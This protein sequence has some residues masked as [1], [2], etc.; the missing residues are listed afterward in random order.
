MS[1]TNIPL[2]IQPADIAGQQLAFQKP[3][4]DYANQ[5]QTNA[6]TGLIGQQTQAASIA[7]QLAQAKLGVQLPII[8]SMNGD[9]TPNA[10]GIS[11]SMGGGQGGQG[12]GGLPPPTTGQNGMI[13]P[14]LGAVPKMVGASV[15]TSQ[16]W[17]KA[18]S[19]AQNA[20][21]QQI[22]QAVASTMGED[23]KADRAAW[24]QMVE[25]Q[26]QSGWMDSAQRAMLF[27]HPEKATS[28]LSS[29]VSPDQQPWMVG[30]RAAA[31]GDEAAKRDLVTI[32][33]DNGDG[34]TTP[35]QVPRSSVLG[36]AG[37]G[38]S[39][40]GGG[41]LRPDLTTAIDSASK[42]YG[43]PASYLTTTARIENP[44]GNPRAVSPTGA[45]GDFQFTGGTADAVG[46]DRAD[47]TDPKQAARGAARLYLESKA[48]LTPRL[49]RAPTDGEVYLAHQQGVGGATALLQADPGAKAVDVYAAAGIPVKNLLVNGG[50]RDMTVGQF[51]N[52]WTSRFDQPQAQPTAAAPG[53]GVITPPGQPGVNPNGLVAT[54]AAGGV[55]SGPPAP[56][57]TT[58]K[59][60]DRDTT[61]LNEDAGAIKANQDLAMTASKN[62]ANML[63]IKSTLPSVNL[64]SLTSAKMP[65]EKFLAS[66]GPDWAKKFAGDVAGLNPDKVADLEKMQKLL[67]SNTV[68]AETSGM[69]AGTRFGAML[70]NFWAKASPNIDMQKPAVA[71]IINYGMVAQQMA[72]DF[73]AGA[74][75]H[76]QTAVDANNTGLQS[77]KYTPYNRL[78][79]YEAQWTNAD[80]KSVHAPQVYVG[81]TNL[82]NGKSPEEA[83]KGLTPAQ[84]QE[85]VHV[86]SRAD[87][88]EMPKVMSRPDVVKWRQSLGG[89]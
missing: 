88:T 34:T 37:G 69:P 72:K 22:G 27:D 71:D 30:A 32:N 15:V 52:K 56:T 28:I 7:N 44:G 25:Q 13:I 19:E 63:E 79:N 20:K 24:N 14:G 45:T 86:L 61:Q 43:V 41:Q 80:P 4:T 16:D 82:M 51:V 3:Y 87:P 65:A 11:G 74:N 48:E 59:L 75:A 18:F 5:Q 58:Q 66:F 50:T 62:Q 12:G 49:G 35:V 68:A 23:G 6:Q 60:I 26:F 2:M 85:A 76:Y 83:F 54:P 33:R 36:A 47:R 55:P 10:G 38:G 8:N 53:G 29:L 39:G 1:G 40:G 81:A 77:G 67:L 21:K 89:Q 70:N 73:V 42:I 57:A 64:G 84:I 31:T 17:S 78:S 9:T 46:L